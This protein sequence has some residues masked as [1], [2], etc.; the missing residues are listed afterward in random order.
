MIHTNV[1]VGEVAEIF[2]GKTPSKED[3]RTSGHPVLKVKD[4]G[5]DLHFSGAFD[6][7][8]DTDF[9]MKYPAKWVKECDTLILNSAHNASHVAS[10]LYFAEKEVACSLPVGE[11]TVVR[12]NPDRIDPALVYWWFSSVEG[13]SAL[14]GA[15]T[16]LHLYPRDIAGLPIPLPPLDEQRRIVG[17]LNRAAKIERLR[18]Q[19]QERLREFVPALFIRMFGDPVENPMGWKLQQFGE[20]V[21]EFRYG[22]SKKC[23][24]EATYGTLPI[25]RI[26]NVLHSVIDWNETK[27]AALDDREANVVRL[28]TGDI[29]FVRTNGNPALIGRCAVFRSDRDTGFASYLIRARILNDGPVLPEYA[30]DALSSTALRKIILGLARTTAGNYNVNIAS[31]SSLPLPVPPLDHQRQYTELVEAA[32]STLVVADARSKMISECTSS[33]MNRLLEADE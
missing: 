28:R 25:L 26:P 11:W 13:R 33:L 12:P 29:L 30:A 22:T 7:F 4:V 10:K 14:R 5:L 19:A 27:F 32:R 1:P 6:N 24:T 21:E 9:A 17:I 2:N 18:V 8:V 3:K 31:L 16:G 20:V 23:S 15:V